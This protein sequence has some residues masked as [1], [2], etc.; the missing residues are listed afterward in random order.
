MVATQTLRPG[1][2]AINISAQPAGI[3]LYRISGEGGNLIGE[4]GNNRKVNR[5]H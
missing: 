5:H 4:E 2:N 3:Y 1:D